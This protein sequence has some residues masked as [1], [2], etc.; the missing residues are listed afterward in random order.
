MNYLDGRFCNH[1][2]GQIIG[3][4]FAVDHL[5]N[6][7]IDDHLCADDTGHGGAVEGRSVN[8]CAV[9]GSLDD[10]VLFGVQSATEFVPFARMCGWMTKI[11]EMIK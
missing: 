3:I 8:V 10:G 2:P 7:R 6:T 4:A 9:L 11:G 1:L 5:F